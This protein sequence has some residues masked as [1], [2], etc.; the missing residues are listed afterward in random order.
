[1][2]L[3]NEFEDPYLNNTDDTKNI[4]HDIEVLWRLIEKCDRELSS[5]ELEN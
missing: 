1:M 4:D 3:S 5:L 2:L